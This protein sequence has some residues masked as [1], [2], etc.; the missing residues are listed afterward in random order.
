MPA[1]MNLPTYVYV[2]TARSAS[3]Y[4]YHVLSSHPEILDIGVKELFFFNRCYDKGL[5][6]YSSFFKGA[7]NYKAAGEFTNTYFIDPIC[8]QRIKEHLPNVKILFSL[9][10]PVERAFNNYYFEMFSQVLMTPEELARGISFQ[11]WATKPVVYAHGDYYKNLKTYFDAFPR[12]NIH[13]SFFDDLKSDPRKFVRDLYSFMGVDPD[14]TPAV[15]EKKIHSLLYP[16]FPRLAQFAFRNVAERLRSAGRPW[17]GS[18][19]RDSRLLR[20]VFFKDVTPDP[21]LMKEALPTLWPM[22]HANDRE[23]EALIGRKLPDGWRDPPA[24]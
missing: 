6:W 2:G 9:R 22:H 13:V 5:E 18:K 7:E 19:L 8:L 16:R 23:L 15:L 11:E 14:Y 1:R 24:L 17:L 21:R 12:E 20:A 10:E 4:M 3:T